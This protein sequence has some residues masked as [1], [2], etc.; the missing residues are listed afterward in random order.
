MAT[1]T[2]AT[3]TEI[4]VGSWVR[5]GGI[6]RVVSDVFS[7]SGYVDLVDGEGGYLA[8]VHVDDL[9]IVETITVTYQACTRCQEAAGE[10]HCHPMIIGVTY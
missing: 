9:T 2:T 6:T 3:A 8:T 7:G 10:C 4:Q 1:G 5:Y